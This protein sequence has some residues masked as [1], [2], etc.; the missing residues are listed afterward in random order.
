MIK[1]H[2]QVMDE[3]DI[4]F[5]R[6]AMRR[7]KWRKISREDVECALQQPD[8]TETTTAGRV[9]VCKTISGRLLKVTASREGKVITVITAVWKG[10]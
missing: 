3:S 8:R 7:M 10:E 4:Q 2:S 1:G 6:H 9:N 5:T